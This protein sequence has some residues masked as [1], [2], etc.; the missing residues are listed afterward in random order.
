MDKH[1]RPITA[2]NVLTVV[3]ASVT[4]VANLAAMDASGTAIRDQA[5][6]GPQDHEARDA[7]LDRRNHIDRITRDVTDVLH[8][9]MKFITRL[10]RD[11]LQDIHTL[12]NQGGINLKET[13]TQKEKMAK[14]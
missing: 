3:G 4:L 5:L 13:R 14:R 9:H 11:L 2:A 8:L 12:I 6:D 1:L 10:R 7:P